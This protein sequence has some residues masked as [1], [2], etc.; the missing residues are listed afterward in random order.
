MKSVTLKGV[1]V[2]I[3]DKVRFV[4]DRNL[5][6]DVDGITKPIVGKIYTISGFT[7]FNGFF[8]KEI[9]NDIMEWNFDGLIFEY[10]PG[11]NINRFVP[12]DSLIEEVRAVLKSKKKV[13]IKIYPEVI[14]T[15]ELS[16]LE[17]E[18]V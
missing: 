13:N 9:K 18:L 4:D 17:L 15:L 8:L 5:Y 12:A 10:E 1:V 14:E 6:S 2:K 3:G 16:P 11:F 7:D